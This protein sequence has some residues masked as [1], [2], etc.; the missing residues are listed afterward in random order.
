LGFNCDGSVK[1]ITDTLN[2]TCPGDTS[3]TT[4]W[5]SEDPDSTATIEPSTIVPECPGKCADDLIT[6][7]MES[8]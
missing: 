7:A 1:L 2:A 3:T 8:P 6:K 4:D 5:T